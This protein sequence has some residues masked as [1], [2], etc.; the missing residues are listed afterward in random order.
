MNQEKKSLRGYHIDKNILLFFIIVIL[1]SASVFGYKLMNYSRCEAVVFDY[2]ALAYRAGEIIKFRD[3]TPKAMQRTWFFGDSSKASR[4]ASPNHRYDEPGEYLV[5]LIVNGQ[6]EGTQR[7]T[8]KEKV[9]RIDST[10]IADFDLPKTVKV[11]ELIQF[12][13]KTKGAT[14]WEWMFGETADIDSKVQNPRYQYE[15]EG[16]KTVILIVNGDKRYATRKK[17]IVTEN[18]KIESKPIAVRP[19][20][21]KRPRASIHKAKPKEDR[22][23]SVIP[24]STSIEQP[25][26]IEEEEKA[27]FLSK[28]AL[29]DMIM[30]VADKKAGVGDFSAYL[31]D[32]INLP[33][34]VNKKSIPFNKFCAK[35][36]GR[37]IIIK[38]LQVTH[39]E[40]NCIKFIKLK[41]SK[42]SIF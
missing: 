4:L 30:K 20:V 18:K 26:T 16:Q 29:K 17:I 12:I 35:I 38:D 14:S 7:I 41:Y 34:E 21:R 15:S 25:P 37:G 23:E 36:R 1:I 27:P 10:R 40:N 31:C 6:C 42:T 2:N 5:K 39:Q 8:I 11:G 32:Q 13:D 33:I 9:E 22:A 19:K 24:D 28:N 3:K